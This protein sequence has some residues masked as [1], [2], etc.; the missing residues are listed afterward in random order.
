MTEHAAPVAPHDAGKSSRGVLIASWIARLV[1]AGVF[2]MGV[3]PKFTGQAGALADKL[4]MGWNS[5]YAIGAV[6]TIAV[7]LILIPKTAVYGAILAGLVMLG[8]I[9]SHF[10][11]VGFEEPFATMFG[12]AIVAFAAAVTTIVL[13]RDRLP[14]QA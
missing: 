10:T 13:L 11:V 6:E 1:V 9:A 7:I 5:V 2:V 4:P 3:I 12:M 14:R 8:A